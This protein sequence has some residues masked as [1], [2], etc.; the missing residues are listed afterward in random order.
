M[1]DVLKKTLLAGV[2][3]TLM[4]KDKVEELARELAKSANLSADKGQ[5][6]V[7]EAVARAK[8]GREEFDAL[9]QRTVNEALKRANVPTR[10]DLARLDARLEKLEQALA[11]KSA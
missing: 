1:I 10:D 5:E 3:L 2:G 8:K 11:S 7:N 4:T 9:V 6:F